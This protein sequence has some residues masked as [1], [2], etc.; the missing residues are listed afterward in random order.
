M[1]TLDRISSWAIVVLII[2]SFVLVS[3]Y[4]GEAGPNLKVQQ[5]I[6]TADY[7]VV[8]SEVSN[9]VKLAKNILEAGNLD[10]AEMLVKEIIQ[11]Y[12]Y[13]GGP[14]MVMGDIFMRSLEPVKS[15]P[16]YKEA[17]DLNPDYLDKKTPLFQG[18]K[19]KI[20]VNE[21]LDEVEKMIDADPG[22][23]AIRQKRKTIYYL[24]RRI[25]GSCG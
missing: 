25:A 15:I 9:K 16:E 24:Q 2:S 19:L 4:K 6:G 1:D 20:A 3:G 5:R 14:H 7:S 11:K 10:K 21:A 8:N 12:P 23:R 18:K 17:V 22:N 13:E